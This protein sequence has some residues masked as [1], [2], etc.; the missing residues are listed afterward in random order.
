MTAGRGAA[1]SLGD[2][3][4]APDMR[5]GQFYLENARKVTIRNSKLYGAGF[6]GV[7]ANRWAQET[8]VENCWIE[9]AGCNGLFFMGW[10]CGRGPFKSVAESYVNKKHVIRNNV[11]YDI[12]RF[13]NFGAGM[14]FNFSGDNLVEHN[15]FHGITHYGVTLKG[16]RR[17][18]PQWKLHATNRDFGRADP[19][20]SSRSICSKSNST[21]SMW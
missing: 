2:A 4:I 7:M 8:L 1:S 20:R 18:D 17:H 13:S 11:F 3:V 9:N 21:A 5:H 16:W 12:G 15:V 14:Y 19:T 10:E 6:M